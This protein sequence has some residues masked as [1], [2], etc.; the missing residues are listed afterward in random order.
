MIKELHLT[1][2]IEDKKLK[3]NNFMK[4]IEPII[5]DSIKKQWL[6]KIG[7]VDSEDEDDFDHFKEAT[8]YWFRGED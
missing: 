4:F 3:F 7:E 6:D 2:I 8:Q 5:D 1:N